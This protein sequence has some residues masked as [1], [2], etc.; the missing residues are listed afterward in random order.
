MLR[1]GPNR[2]WIL[3]CNT[4]ATSDS[5]APKSTMTVREE[6]HRQTIRSICSLDSF[7]DGL[8]YRELLA[9]A[10]GSAPRRYGVYGTNPAGRFGQIDL[11][12]EHA[13]TSSELNRAKH[14]VF[15]GTSNRS[16]SPIRCRQGLQNELCAL[17]LSRWQWRRSVRQGASCQGSA[18]RGGSKAKR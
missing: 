4:R 10:F 3:R 13:K 6:T 18:L 15:H 1:G 8:S 17:S 12:R 9:E 5:M 2:P 16:T 11:R 14:P 7:S